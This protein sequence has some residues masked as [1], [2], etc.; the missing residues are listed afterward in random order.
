M[1]QEQ[2]R[3]VEKKSALPEEVSQSFFQL[4]AV[5]I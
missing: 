4:I 5:D 2:F 3:N 1:P